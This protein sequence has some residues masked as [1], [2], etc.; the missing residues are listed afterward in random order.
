MEP[1]RPAPGLASEQ[2]RRREK[3]DR[4]EIP[5]DMNTVSRPLPASSGGP[6]IAIVAHDEGRRGLLALLC[7]FIHLLERCPLV[8]TSGPA[9]DCVREV[10]LPAVSAAD[11]VHGGDG[12][13]P[14]RHEL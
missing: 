12:P 1:W 4:E 9:L 13:P 8:A 14:R 11:D 2:Q 5:H 7:R 6:S 10:G 3:A